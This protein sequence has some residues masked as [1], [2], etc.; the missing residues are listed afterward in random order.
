MRIGRD[1][2]HPVNAPLVGFRGMKV[3]LVDTITLPIVVGAYPQQIA[4]EVNFLIIDCFS[5]YNAIIGRQTLNSWKVVTS[6]YHL[7]VKFPINYGT[8][9]V[10]EDQLAAKEF[11]LAMLA[12][13][14]HMQTMNIEERRVA[15]KPTEALEDVPLDESNPERFTRIRT[16]MEK[17]TKQDLIQFFR[18][19]I[20]V[21]AWSH[22]NMPG[23][24][25]SVITH[26]LNVYPSSK[27]VH[28][29]KRVFAPE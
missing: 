1:Q 23:I 4:K 6:T 27:P 28:Q 20:Y 2:L 16:S 21:F 29:K 19:S 24:D 22:E 11:Y 13:D 8:G 17:K 7:S 9:Q 5:S 26:H 3:Q 18:K 25:P 12:M 10:Q 14:E 15:A